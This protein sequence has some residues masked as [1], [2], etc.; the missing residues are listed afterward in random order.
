MSLPCT[1]LRHVL[2]SGWLLPSVVVELE[3]KG[4]RSEGARLL[5]PVCTRSV[6]V[7]TQCVGPL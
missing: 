6:C 2:V 4:L 5:L 1:V 7:C 3:R